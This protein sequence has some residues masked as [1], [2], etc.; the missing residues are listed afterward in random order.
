MRSV[1]AKFWVTEINHRH[2]NDSTAINVEVKLEPVY[3]DDNK[4][5]SR[6]TPSGSMALVITNPDAIAQFEIGKP[7]Y[8]DFT[9]AE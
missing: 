3:D 6:W 1:R 8:V 4:D 9:P 7:Y 5:W 2:S